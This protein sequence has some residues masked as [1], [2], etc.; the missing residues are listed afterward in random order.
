MMAQSRSGD[1]TDM[2]KRP[3]DPNQLAKRIVDLAIGERCRS[4]NPRPQ[5]Q[6]EAAR[7]H[8]ADRAMEAEAAKSDADGDMPPGNP[9]AEPKVT[10]LTDPAAAWT[11]KGQMKVLFAYGIAYLIDLPAAI[12]ERSEIFPHWPRDLLIVR[13]RRRTAIHLSIAACVRLDHAGID[14]EALAAYQ[15]D[16]HARVNHVLE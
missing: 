5:R 13:P 12:I 6:R 11:N 16:P 2:P 4:K 7:S 9:S 10:S 3:R 1:L 15:S 14:G 8:T